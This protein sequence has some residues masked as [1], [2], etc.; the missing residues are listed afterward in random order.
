MLNNIENAPFD[1]IS[2]K[3]NFFRALLQKFLEENLEE[4]GNIYGL[5]KNKYIDNCSFLEY[6]KDFLIQK[7]GAAKPSGFTTAI[8]I[9]FFLIL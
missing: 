7:K 2:T 1:S 8:S 5:G 3:K 6:V 9:K 4:Y